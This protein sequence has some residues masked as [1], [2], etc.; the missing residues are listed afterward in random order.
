MPV[1]DGYQATRAIRAL[2]RPDAARIPII[3]LTADAFEEDRKRCLE[4]GMDD[5]LAKPVE[6]KVLKEMLGKYM[7]KDLG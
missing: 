3:A 7:R 1:M 4:A 5:F 6:I 2:E